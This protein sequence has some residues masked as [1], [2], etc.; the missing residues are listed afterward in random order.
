MGQSVGRV[1]LM[2]S[3]QSFLV[4]SGGGWRV[5][6]I[7]S[8]VYW[9]VAVTLQL[10]DGVFSWLMNTMDMAKRNI[11]WGPV[12]VPVN[13]RKMVK[14]DFTVSKED[15]MFSSTFIFSRRGFKSEEGD[16]TPSLIFS[17]PGAYYVVGLFKVCN[18]VSWF[19]SL[20]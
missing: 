7:M 12:T 4:V 1:M 6:I 10:E 11:V 18:L 14:A 8:L 17:S 5:D 16:S 13:A 3:L 19:P 2:V 20:S 15:Q 9:N